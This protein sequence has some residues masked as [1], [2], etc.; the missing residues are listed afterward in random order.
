MWVEHE[1]YGLVLAIC[2]I[3]AWVKAVFDTSISPGAV[4]EHIAQVLV[5]VLGLI[6]AD[7]I[8]GFLRDGAKQ[9]TFAPDRALLEKLL[10]GTDGILQRIFI[11]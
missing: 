6:A 3:G 8:H 10:C 1:C 5:H 7:F 9:G 2:W 11:G 4:F